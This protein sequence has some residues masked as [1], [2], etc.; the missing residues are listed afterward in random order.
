M[1]G[2]FKYYLYDLS[3]IYQLYISLSVSAM[4][5]PDRLCPTYNSTTDGPELF[6][7]LQLTCSLT[8]N[9]YRLFYYMTYQVKTK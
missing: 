8:Q 2:L 3:A 5:V 1:I 4:Q 6:K 9:V 7:S